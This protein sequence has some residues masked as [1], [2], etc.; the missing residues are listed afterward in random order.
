MHQ[1]NVR[2]LVPVGDLDSNKTNVHSGFLLRLF[3]WGGIGNA[4]FR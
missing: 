1:A 3:A 2:D 4:L